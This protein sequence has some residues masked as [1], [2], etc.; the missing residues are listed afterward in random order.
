[1]NAEPELRPPEPTLGATAVDLTAPGARTLPEMLEAA[2]GSGRRVVFL[3]SSGQGEPLGYRELYERS[4][5]TG[6]AL[7]AAGFRPGDRLFVVLPTGEDFLRVFLGSLLAGLQPCP[8]SPPQGA[9]SPELYQEKLHGLVTALGIRGMVGRGPLAAESRRHLEA[10]HLAVAAEE[11]EAADGTLPPPPDDPEAIAFLQLTSG[12][13]GLPKG[14][15][16]SHRAALANLRQIAPASGIEP[17]DVMVSWLPLFHDMGLVGALLL[18]LATG[19]DLILSSPFTFLRRPALWIQAISRYRGTHTLAP[20]FAY[21]QLLERLRERDLEGLDLSSWRVAYVGAEPVHADVLEDFERRLAPV[22]LSPT[23]LLPCYG[24]AEATL[25]IAFKPHREPYRTLSVSR[26]ALATEE[27][28]EPPSTPDDEL[29]LVSC[30]RPLAGIHVVIRGPEGEALPE[31]RQ[32]EI[33]LS[34][35]SMF[36]GYRNLQEPT[37]EEIASGFRTGDLGFLDRGELFVTGRSKDLIIVAGENHHPAELEWAAARVDDATIRR[38]AAF[39][40]D[41]PKLGTERLCL[42]VEVDRRGDGAGDELIEAIR[43]SVREETGL[44]V[45]EVELVPRGTLPVTTSGKIRRGALR[46]SF[47]E[48]RARG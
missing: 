28:V 12:S 42:L 44:V 24:M 19:M 14:V 7:L 46:E 35:P 40:I 41:D 4:R 39:G 33:V 32:G 47:L 9:Q 37:P 34:G 38:V 29:V 6:A 15:E 13:T 3:A 11:L 22:N 25:A 5:A 43:R 23:T 31:R 26:R 16:I 8:M 27:R 36:S 10:G 17:G 21:R 48:Q 30:G 2:A 20:T 18:S 45:S 1:M